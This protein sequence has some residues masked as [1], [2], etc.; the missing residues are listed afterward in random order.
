[1]SGKVRSMSTIHKGKKIESADI[2]LKTGYH[3]D[4]I[5]TNQKGG[6]SM[7]IVPLS[8]PSCGG[9]LT[10]DSSLE[11]AVCKYCGKPYIVKDAIVNNYIHLHIGQATIQADTINLSTQKDFDIKAGEL[12][13]YSGEKQDVIIP[14]NVTE[15]GDFAFEKMNIKSVSIPKGITKIGEKA[16][17][18][19]KQLKTINI[20]DSVIEIQRYAFEWSGLTSIHLPNSVTF[21]GYGAFS[22]CHDL[23][24]VKIPNVKTLCGQAFA[25]TPFWSG[26]CQNCGNEL[27][28]A[29]FL[30]QM[31]GFTK[32]CKK[33][34]L[35]YKV[36]L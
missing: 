33:C 25:N 28:K 32:Q 21:I 14:E 35:V 18:G 17:G 22:H 20:P 4:I 24:D 2:G 27:S 23:R 1:M 34:E 7:P 16:F 26:K 11:A 9:N 31:R 10:V 5:I 12:I 6:S 30:D 19:C 3:Y 13:K 8:C 15:I 36:S 29:G